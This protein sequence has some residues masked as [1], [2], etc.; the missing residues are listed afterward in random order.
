MTVYTKRGDEGNTDLFSGERVSKS[1][2]RIEA[3][4]AVD[5]LNSLLGMAISTLNDD[6]SDQESF[7]VTVQN[8]LHTICASLANSETDKGDPDITPDHVEFLEDR[9][10]ELEEEL[11]KLQAFILPGG[12]EPGSTLHYARSV[13]RRAE[14]SVIRAH[15]EHQVNPHLIKYINRLSDSLFVEARLVNHRR[16]ETEANP[17]YD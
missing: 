8:H 10:D 14:R 2:T 12:S 11:P 16:S 15:E 1:D 5:E 17:S 9:I 3:Y 6:E 7:L 4:G 13:C